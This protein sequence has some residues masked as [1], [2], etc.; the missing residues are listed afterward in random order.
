ME[1]KKK[2]SDYFGRN[3]VHFPTIILCVCVQEGVSVCVTVTF[4]F[5]CATRFVF[6]KKMIPEYWTYFLFL[7]FF[8]CRLHCIWIL[9]IQN[10]K[11]IYFIGVSSMFSWCNL[12]LKLHNFCKRLV[13]FR[14]SLTYSTTRTTINHFS[15]SD[16][17]WWHV[18][19][20]VSGAS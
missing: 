9:S 20:P 3:I 2:V 8:L 12:S 15:F 18:C 16:G 11:Q 17:H 1:K 10:W 14:S 5:Y 13:W 7:V 6:C 4:G 19:E